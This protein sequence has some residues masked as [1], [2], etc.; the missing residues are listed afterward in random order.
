MSVY[1]GR[2]NSLRLEGCGIDKNFHERL[3]LPVK[4]RFHTPTL[5]HPSKHIS[6]PPSCLIKIKNPFLIFAFFLSNSF[7]IIF[8]RI[9]ILALKTIVI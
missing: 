7:V 2:L 1:S 8:F 3:S 5:T 9:V 6:K 4:N